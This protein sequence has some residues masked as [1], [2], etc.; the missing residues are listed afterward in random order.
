[1]RPKVVICGSFH[2]DPTGLARAYRELEATG[3]R[4]LSPLSVNFT[5]ASVP[6]VRTRH[7]ND[8]SIQELEKFHLRAINE[9]DLVW[10]HAPEGYV[11]LSA[12]FEIGYAVAIGK[13]VF[14]SF[15]LT[16]EML[17]SQITIVASVFESLE[18][19][20]YKVR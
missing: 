14:S 2:R 20:H 7:E 13:P 4:I 15:V 8:F 18:S 11:G 3:C 5:D 9:S 10:L 6:V 16:D 1:M 19:L 12:S 17:H